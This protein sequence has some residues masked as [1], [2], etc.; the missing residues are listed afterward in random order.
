MSAAAWM[1][2]K[3]FLD[4]FL[5][6]AGQKAGRILVGEFILSGA[7]MLKKFLV[8]HEPLFNAL[9]PVIRKL[10]QQVLP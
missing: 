9:L 1:C 7:D 3:N 4:G 2:E 8:S 10:A 6:S 5:L